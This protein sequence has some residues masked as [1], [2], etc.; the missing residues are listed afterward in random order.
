MGK[1]Q[2]PAVRIISRACNIRRFIYE[3]HICKLTGRLISIHAG[4]RRWSSWAQ[5]QAH[6]GVLNGTKMKY[7]V[8]HYAWSDEYVEALLTHPSLS[9]DRQRRALIERAEAR[10]ILY[11]LE[12][13]TKLVQDHIRNRLKRHGR[14]R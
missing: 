10:S 5:A 7:G 12:V 6:Y 9:K 3:A 1:R 14:R 4:C 13:D 8:A 2:K 11:K